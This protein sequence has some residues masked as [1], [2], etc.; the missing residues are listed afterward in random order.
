MYVGASATVCKGLPNKI[1]LFRITWPPAFKKN[2]FQV[3]GK[4]RATFGEPS[5]P[6]IVGQGPDTCLSSMF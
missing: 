2:M 4:G 5:A 6:P 1:P 3:L